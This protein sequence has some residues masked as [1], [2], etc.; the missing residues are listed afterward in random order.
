[1]KIADKI[2]F[3]NQ[4]DFEKYSKFSYLAGKCIHIPN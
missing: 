2:V 4:E 1:M 3:I